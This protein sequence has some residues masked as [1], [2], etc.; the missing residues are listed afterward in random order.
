M[1]FQNTWFCLALTYHLSWSRCFKSRFHFCWEYFSHHNVFL[2]FVLYLLFIK[3]LFR[4]WFFFFIYFKL[5]WLKIAVLNYLTKFC[6]SYYYFVSFWHCAVDVKESHCFLQSLM[7][8]GILHYL[9]SEWMC[10]YCSLPSL[11][12]LSV[13]TEIINQL[14]VLS[15]SVAIPLFYYLMV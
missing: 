15:E 5:N 2:N 9:G 8:I 13:F 4:Y 3:F 11:E 6:Y 1:C 10:I 7:F 12:F 14:S